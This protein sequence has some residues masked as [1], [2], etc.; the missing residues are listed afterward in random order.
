MNTHQLVWWIGVSENF[1]IELASVILTGKGQAIIRKS[2]WGLSADD[3]AKE[4]VALD[5]RIIPNWC[6]G[7]IQ[8]N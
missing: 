4:I 6:Y 2:I 7:L 5:K 1:I 8:S 3:I